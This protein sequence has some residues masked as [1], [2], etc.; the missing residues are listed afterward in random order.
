MIPLGFPLSIMPWKINIEPTPPKINIEP[1]AMM[2]MEDEFPFP[3]GPY[4]Q[5]NH[6]NLL[7]CKDQPIEKEIHPNQTSTFGSHGWIPRTP[8]TP[9]PP[10]TLTLSGE[11]APIHGPGRGNP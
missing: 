2:V 1:E 9:K 5:V 11:T 8:T 6:V 4:S 3:G 7:G 10:K